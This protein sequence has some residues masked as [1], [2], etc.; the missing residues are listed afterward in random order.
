MFPAP[1]E[2]LHIPRVDELLAE[3][4]LDPDRA[5]WLERSLALGDSGRE[6]SLRK[7]AFDALGGRNVHQDA[8]RMRNLML[9]VGGYMASQAI[10]RGYRTVADYF[11]NPIKEYNLSYRKGTATKE[12]PFGE[13]TPTV[14]KKLTAKR[15]YRDLERINQPERANKRPKLLTLPRGS[16]RTRYSGTRTTGVGSESMYGFGRS[17]YRRRSVY[18]RTYR[19]RFRRIF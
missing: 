3:R 14:Y 13:L 18:R 5:Q 6:G 15:V 4:F 9:G 2:P 16:N 1:H 12:N 7:R 19:R 8:K 17:R 11:G 10:A